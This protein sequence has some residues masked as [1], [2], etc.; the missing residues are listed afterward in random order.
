MS[1]FGGFCSRYR[2]FK[3]RQAP[4]FKSKRR[5]VGHSAL[6][7]FDLKSARSRIVLGVA[8]GEIAPRLLDNW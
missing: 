1:P 7:V 5:S 2:Y 4:D 6:K 3:W 8:P